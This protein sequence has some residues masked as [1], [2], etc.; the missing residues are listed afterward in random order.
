MKEK[1]RKHN[2]S[3]LFALI[4]SVI[5]YFLLS[6]MAM[7]WFGSPQYV[8]LYQKAIP[9]MG[10]AS[11]AYFLMAIILAQLRTFPYA[12]RPFVVNFVVIVVNS[13]QFIALAAGRVYFSLSFLAVYFIFTNIW[14]GVEAIL[15]RRFSRYVLAVVRGG[16][17]IEEKQFSNLLLK[18]FDKP[19]DLPSGVDGIVI[20]FRHELSNEWLEFVTRCVMDDI[21]V[22]STDDFVETQYGTI[23]LENM[24]TARSISF[25]KA[26]IYITIKRIMD[27]LLVFLFMPVWAPILLV[28]AILVK[29]ESPGP[30]IFSQ[31]RIGRRGKPF[32]IYKIRSMHTDSE[33]NG[34]AF[35]SEMDSRIT[36]IGSFIR[37]F[38]IDEFPQF[39]NILKGDM[40]LI[41]PRPEQVAFVECFNQTIPYYQLRHI[42]RPG[43]SGWAQITQGY[44]AGTDETAVKLSLDL[45]YVKHMS[46][47]LDFLISVR[48]I[49]TIL[50]GFGS[51]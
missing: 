17:P 7:N 12:N 14:F 5:G 44:A 32:T 23:I 13:L 6:F 15:R 21:P 35:A 28:V 9:L 29:L 3:I 48:T 31:K 30:L 24:T 40:S 45:F 8:G 36:H 33:S 34:V 22:I 43:I 4:W 50:S 38:R 10:G 46:F 2:F 1:L 25:Q 26:S 27:V 16:Y 19:E 51:R 11:A 20:D 37:K 18:P 47:V 39:F 42:V 41:G 49:A